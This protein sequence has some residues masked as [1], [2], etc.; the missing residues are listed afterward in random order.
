MIGNEFWTPVEPAGIVYQDSVYVVIPT[1]E[2]WRKIAKEKLDRVLLEYS[3][4][5]KRWGVLEASANT[6]ATAILTTKSLTEQY[7][8]LM[9]EDDSNA[10]V[11][12]L[13]PKN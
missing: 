1:P 5:N 12:T 4:V 11:V 2:L 7:N 13:R 6:V 10:N 9:K 3:L 8:D